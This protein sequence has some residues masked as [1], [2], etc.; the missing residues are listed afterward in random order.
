MNEEKGCISNIAE[1][2]GQ[3]F[4]KLT[5][6]EL[7]KEDQKTPRQ[8]KRKVI[9]AVLFILF[10][11]L[12]VGIVLFLEIKNE[13][14]SFAG[15][16]ELGRMMSGGSS[17][18]LL[19]AFS[20]YLLNIFTN[21]LAFF[22]LIKRCG[23]G[24]RFGLALRLSILGKYYDSITPW[25]AGGQPYQMVYMAKAN[26]DTPT[27]CTLPV[28][29]YTIRI[30]WVN[31]FT[32]LIFIFAPVNVSVLIRVGAYL[33][34]FNTMFLPL[35]L[36]AFSGNVPFML[37]MTR[38][39]VGILYK[40]KLIKNYDKYINK[41]QDLVDSFLAAFKYLGKHKSMIFIIGALSL[42]DCIAVTSI[43]FFIVRSFGNTTAPFFK[44]MSQAFYA[45]LSAGIVPTPGASG[46]AEGSFYSVF[47][48][49]VPVGYLFWAVILWRI[50]V[51]Y[52]PLALGLIVQFIDWLKGKSKVALVR[53]DVAWRFKKTFNTSNVPDKT[54]GAKLEK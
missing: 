17:V 44:T 54:G 34:L 48:S 37:K 31:A 18:F 29:K 53:T 3:S 21:A 5:L 42:I 51:F 12:A 25:N 1:A 14:S 7:E 13:K 8:K 27:A 46:A 32:A 49:A 20:M 6:P 2:D 10:N 36:I 9:A 38:G 16:S 30:I 19:I 35:L 28:I 23:Y 15:A 39:V 47:E 22:F 24:N 40:L 11:V 4:P 26:I 43:P 50:L 52:M 33:G 45:T 41:A